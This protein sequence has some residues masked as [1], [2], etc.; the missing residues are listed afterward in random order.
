MSAGLRG[1][2]ILDVTV[3]ERG[4]TFNAVDWPRSSVYATTQLVQNPATLT[5]RIS[6]LWVLRQAASAPVPRRSSSAICLE[7]ARLQLVNQLIRVGEVGVVAV[8]NSW[9]AEAAAWSSSFSLRPKSPR[10]VRY[11]AAGR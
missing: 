1:L 4:Q 5:S 3:P 8:R 7:H 9:R 2:G 10:H 6:V 11:H